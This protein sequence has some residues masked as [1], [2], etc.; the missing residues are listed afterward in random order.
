MAVRQADEADGLLMRLDNLVADFG[1]KKRLVAD[2]YC[3]QRAGLLINRFL[4]GLGVSAKRIQIRQHL[5]LN[6]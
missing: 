2:L 3:S 1:P 4:L 5:A 6:F